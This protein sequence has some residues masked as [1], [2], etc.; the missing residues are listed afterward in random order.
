M[1]FPLTKRFVVC[2]EYWMLPL[3][4]TNE[5]VG[6]PFL[7]F[8]GN[9]TC[10]RKAKIRPDEL[11]LELFH[12]PVEV[13][14]ST[15][16]RASWVAP[17]LLLLICASIV[18]GFIAAE[19][20]TSKAQK[21]MRQETA[22]IESNPDFADLS[23]VERQQTRDMIG[24][25]ADAIPTILIVTA[26]IVYD[27]GLVLSMLLIA[28]FLRIVSKPSAPEYSYA[29]WFSLVVWSYLPLLLGL[30]ASLIAAIVSDQ[31]IEQP[32]A[33]LKWLPEGWFDQGAAGVVA[34]IDIPL[35]LSI[36]LMSIGFRVYT[37][38]SKLGSTGI[39][40][41][42]FVIYYAVWTIAVTVFGDKIG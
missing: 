27:L 38:W 26:P 13:F 30:L 32:L 33:F 14:K 34:D 40:L 17:L 10:N 5:K 18:K 6:A 29:H 20:D 1:L 7:D 37:G 19:I 11:F 42:P 23:D 4:P 2:L 12:S 41:I 35:L 3:Y 25:V 36:T 16:E 39:V 31:R 22:N 8:L 21:A 24:S 15:R 28:L 9:N